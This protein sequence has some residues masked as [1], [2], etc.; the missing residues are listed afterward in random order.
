VN[1]RES[2]SLLRRLLTR[3]RPDTGPEGIVLTNF[4]PKVLAAQVHSSLFKE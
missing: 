3:G 4:E 2:V 1:F